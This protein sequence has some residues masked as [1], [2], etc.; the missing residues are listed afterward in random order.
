MFFFTCHGEL[1]NFFSSDALNTF[2][3]NETAH[4]RA[5]REGGYRDVLLIDVSQLVG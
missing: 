1:C 3:C 2:V 5:C 4:L